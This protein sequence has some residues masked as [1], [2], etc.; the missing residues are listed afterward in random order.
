[1]HLRMSNSFIKDRSKDQDRRRD[2]FEREINK[3]VSSYN[4]VAGTLR[5]Y[6]K[7]TKSKDKN[8]NKSE[9]LNTAI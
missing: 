1:M 2:E 5:E 8:K 4:V 9:M 7:Q 6:F 3:K